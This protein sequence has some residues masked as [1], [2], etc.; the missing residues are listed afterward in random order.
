[1]EKREVWQNTANDPE[2]GLPRLLPAIY[3]AYWRVKKGVLPGIGKM[4]G[5]A[6]TL[7]DNTFEANWE[8]L[9]E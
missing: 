9:E 3:L 5:Y 4:L 8:I 7:N 2:T 6:Y 1:M